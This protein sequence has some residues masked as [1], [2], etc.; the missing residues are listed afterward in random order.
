MNGRGIGVFAVDRELRCKGRDGYWAV[1]DCGGVPQ[2]DGAGL[3][4][5]TAQFAIREAAAC[6]RNILATIDGKA[7]AQTVRAEVAD[8][9]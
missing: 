9:D 7:L 6:A 4:P 1:G 2:P 5:P 8:G 3:C